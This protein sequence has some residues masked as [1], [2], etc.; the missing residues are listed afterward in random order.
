[1]PVTS[2]RPGGAPNV[3][4]D[5]PRTDA[6]DAT[7]I[8]AKAD[9]AADA[10]KTDGASS[11]RDVDQVDHLDRGDAA[12]KASKKRTDP[13]VFAR[14]AA[15]I[16][17][18]A[19]TLG[20]AVVA[21]TLGTH[22]HD[23][24]APLHPAT[25]IETVDTNHTTDTPTPDPKPVLQPSLRPGASTVP[26]SLTHAPGATTHTSEPT[27]SVTPTPPAGDTTNTLHPARR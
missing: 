16:S 27:A 26:K 6:P 21:T 15:A 17:F 24:G 12:A 10:P 1:M 7:G 9:G 13:V 19:L 18:L 8:A 20:V 23:S 5:Q 25:R 4:Q 2:T 14:K 3:L 22:S 11:A